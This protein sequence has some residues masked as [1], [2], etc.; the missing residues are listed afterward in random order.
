[1]YD[2]VFC[3]TLLI[4]LATSLLVL[5]K[6]SISFH[7]KR[8]LLEARPTD[9]TVTE[10]CE[11]DGRRE[12]GRKILLHEQTVRSLG[13]RYIG[14]FDAAVISWKE[15][16]I[17]HLVI[18]RKFPVNH[19]PSKTRPEDIFQLGLY[20][21]ALV[22]SGVS[23]NSTLLM[24]IYCVQERAERCLRNS[25]QLNC[26]RCRQARVFVSRF[27]QRD[28]EKTLKRLDEVWY[29]A[30]RPRPAASADSCRT[31]PFSA[32]GVCNYAAI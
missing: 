30:R 32:S 3:F 4:G 12:Q 26:A 24:V 29:S 21:L 6:K 9:M 23:C 20:S 31:C 2:A 19:L 27:K 14:S 7:A 15:S 18:E 8:I 10:L 5:S 13:H 16:P 17:A 28:V 1:M 25:S 22:E 11:L